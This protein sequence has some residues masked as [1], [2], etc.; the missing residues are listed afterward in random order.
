MDALKELWRA[1]WDGDLVALDRLLATNVDVN[2]TPERHDWPALHAAI[3]QME[4]EA[5]RR[6]VRAGADVN[7]EQPCGWTPLQHAVDIESDAAHQRDVPREEMPTDLIELL[8]SLGARPTAEA[9]NTAERYG[10]PRASA[11]LRSRGAC[12]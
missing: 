8:L 5:V 4:F 3:E 2:A 11:V 10:N 1:A 7:L 9:L 12:A 6:L